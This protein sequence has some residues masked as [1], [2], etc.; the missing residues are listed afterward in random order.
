MAYNIPTNYDTDNFT[1]G[2]GV[3]FIGVLAN[4]KASVAGL[5]E[6][7]DISSVGAVRSGGTFSV[8]RTKLEVNQGSPITLVKQ[9]VT[10][11]TANITVNGIEWDLDRLRLALGA[12]VTTTTS[13]VTKQLGIGGD[14]NVV[15]CAVKLTHDMPSGG[16]ITIKLW[17]AQGS[18]E[19]TVTFGDDLHE[20]PYSFDALECGATGWAGLTLTPSERL[21]RIEYTAP[22]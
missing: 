2:P 7:T 21:F 22:V 16:Q 13:G 9:F 18:G 20:I 8:T 19:M 1:F 5:S 4:G 12:G 10:Q 6:V 15:E 3:L 14:L 11:E 17:R